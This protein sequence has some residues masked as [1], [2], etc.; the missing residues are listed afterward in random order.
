MLCMLC[1][2]ATTHLTLHHVRCLWRS[3]KGAS[4]ARRR[5]G[6]RRRQGEAALVA[7]G[8]PRLL[9]DC[10]HPFAVPLTHPPLVQDMLDGAKR[11]LLLV[12]GD[13]RICAVK[14]DPE[15]LAQGFGQDAGALARK[16]GAGRW[17]ARARDSA[18]MLLS[19][20]TQDSLKPASLASVLQAPTRI[21]CPPPASRLQTL[22]DLVPDLQRPAGHHGAWPSQDALLQRLAAHASAHAGE[23]RREGLEGSW[24]A[25][26]L[27]QGSPPSPAAILPATPPSATQAAACAPQCA[28]ACCPTATRFR[29]GPEW[30]WAP[31]ASSP[32][33]ERGMWDGGSR[34]VGSRFTLGDGC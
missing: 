19:G 31:A 20:S 4:A 21:R 1:I 23:A 11:L 29:S 13:G 34:A 7:G 18:G 27:Q 33:G 28:W 15:V 30:L 5:L 25:C 26:M 17:S 10:T 16:V 3:T 9:L 6:R 2:L 14:A 22:A 32:A 8:F 24:Q 12:R